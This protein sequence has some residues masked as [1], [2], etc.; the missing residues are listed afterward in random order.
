MK[1]SSSPARVICRSSARYSG[2][3]KPTTV[4]TRNGSKA[5]ATPYARASSVSW[6]TPWWAPADS[7]LPWPVSKYITFVPM[8]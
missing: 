1:W 6:S 3:M 4:F 8:N 7:A 2:P 5:R